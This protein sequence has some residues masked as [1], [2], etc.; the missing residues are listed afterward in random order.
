M[1]YT[2]KIWLVN[3]ALAIISVF[4]GVKTVD[5]WIGDPFEFEKTNKNHIKQ[6]TS[7][8]VKEVL[9]PGMKAETVYEAVVKNN[10]F[11]PERK[12]IIAPP[13]PDVVAEPVVEAPPVVEIIPEVEELKIE[14][15]NVMIYG[16]M[17]MDSF[18]GALV[19]NFVDE[20]SG[21]RQKWVKKGEMIGDLKLEDVKKD[22]AIFSKNENGVLEK[23]AV[24]LYTENKKN[25][26]P[27]GV[28]KD[29]NEPQPKILTT[30]QDKKSNNNESQAADS[31]ADDQY[32]IIKTPFGNFKRKKRK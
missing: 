28:E 1:I 6:N 19:N 17:I 22:R 26:K 4:I 23:Y 32:E 5:L 8:D 7:Q 24:L 2:N 29:R 12:E 31:V 3:A 16:V 18:T 20:K 14:D 30:G 10:L 15:R 21:K 13:V 11:S 25:D 9:T 27:A